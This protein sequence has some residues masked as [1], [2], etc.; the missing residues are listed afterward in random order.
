MA[1]MGETGFCDELSSLETLYREQTG[2]DLAK[3]YRPPEGT[4]SASNLTWAEKLGYKTVFWSL[5]YKDWN[6]DVA[7]SRE[8]AIEILKKNTHPGAI[9]LLHPTTALNV[10]IL[11]EMI[12]Y[13]R[14]EG[15]TF[16]TL[17]MIEG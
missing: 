8:K 12:E 1:Q 3:F 17:D 16:G 5:M 10:D 6:D 13:W 4:F 2:K 9:V 14:A 7:P 11:R 15:Y